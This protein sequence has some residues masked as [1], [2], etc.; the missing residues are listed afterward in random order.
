M[1]SGIMPTCRCG[2][3]QRVKGTFDFVDEGHLAVYI[4]DSGYN[5][6]NIIE[7]K[8]AKRAI[9][10]ESSLGIHGNDIITIKHNNESVAV[11]GHEIKSGSKPSKKCFVIMPS[12]NHG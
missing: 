5:L 9:D 3:G 2:C 8:P 11:A 12:G 4:H 10:D 1:R 6:Q 7:N